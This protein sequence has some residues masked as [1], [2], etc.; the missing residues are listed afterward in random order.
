MISDGRDAFA[1][2]TTITCTN[3]AAANA[4][5]TNVTYDDSDGTCV[6]GNG[7]GSSTALRDIVFKSTTGS[8]Q[9][10]YSRSELA[11]AAATAR[12]EDVVLALLTP[13]LVMLAQLTA[14]MSLMK[15]RRS[16]LMGRTGRRSG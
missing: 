13:L 15:P 9:T 5:I 16:P 10:R 8:R 4:S 12:I 2:T 14:L 7:L 1:A 6:A 3:L 11:V